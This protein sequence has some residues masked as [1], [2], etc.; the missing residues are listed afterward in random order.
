[1]T[2]ID[3]EALRHAVGAGGSACDQAPPSYDSPK[4]GAGALLGAVYRDT[5]KIVPQPRLERAQAELA[6]GANWNNLCAILRVA[7]KPDYQP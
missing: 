4:A 3:T 6:K 5:G 1:M 2:P 7:V